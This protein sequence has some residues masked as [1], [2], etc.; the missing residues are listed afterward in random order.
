[1]ELFSYLLGKKSGGGGGGA[2]LSK[3]FEPTISAVANSDDSG[4]M[5]IVKT[6]PETTK[7]QGNDLYYAFSEFKGTTIPLIDTSNVIGMS[8]TFNECH[9]LTTIPLLDMSNVQ[10]TATMFK[11]CTS[12]TTIPLINTQNVTNMNSM[13]YGCT[14][15]TTV[16]L[17]NTAKTTGMNSLFS[18]CP[19]LT[20]ESLD[21]ILQMCMNSAV[22]QTNR[23]KLTNIGFTAED[24]PVSKLETLPH[25]QEFLS[26]GWIVGY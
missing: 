16:P 19:N 6:I 23:K 25:Y 14:S 21:N 5:H 15:L 4:I 3:Y 24:Y 10:S 11:N 2:D 7:V 1:M 12:L 22:T 20:D 17:L 18:G 8:A 9:N 26:S 13:F